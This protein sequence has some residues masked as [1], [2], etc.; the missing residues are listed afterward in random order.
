MSARV[1]ISARVRVRMHVCALEYD[2]I[3]KPASHPLA[4]LSSSPLTLHTFAMYP[5]CVLHGLCVLYGLSSGHISTNRLFAKEALGNLYW[6]R[7]HNNSDAVAG[8][9]D[10]F[11]DHG[12]A[13]PEAA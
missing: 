1:C 6:Q 4:T 8:N 12:L 2:P 7:A 11:N 10:L 3:S 9:K 13:S 5:L